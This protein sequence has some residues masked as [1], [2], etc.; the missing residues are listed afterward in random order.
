MKTTILFL[1]AIASVYAQSNDDKYLVAMQKQIEM[2]YKAQASEELQSAINTFDRIGSAE[3]S[4]WEPFY[5]SAFGNLMLATREKEPGKK[6]ALLDLSMASLE[7]AKAILPND[8]EIT[9]LEGFVHMM[10]V[11]VDPASRGQQYSGLA[12]QTFGKAVQ[13]NPENPRALSLM[14]QMQMGTA[15]FFGQPATEACE[16]ARKA[17]AIFNQTSSPVAPLAPVW[18]KGMTEKLVESCGQ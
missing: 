1:F 10:R 6:D 13:L 2:V 14:A 18:G 9:A 7:K 16:T 12:M 5:Y 8:S 4:K 3:K 17:L 11:T 15:K